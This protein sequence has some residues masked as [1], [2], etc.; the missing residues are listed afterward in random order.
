MIFLV[1]KMAETHGKY[2]SRKFTQEDLNNLTKAVTA[3]KTL[4]LLGIL[5]LLIGFSLQLV[6]FFAAVPTLTQSH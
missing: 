6:A 2:D 1:Q 4:N 3:S 5:F